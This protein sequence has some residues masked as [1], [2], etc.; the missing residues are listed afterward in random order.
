M[1][2]FCLYKSAV[3][4]LKLSVQKKYHFHFNAQL[5]VIF[6]AVSYENRGF[7]ILIT[8]KRQFALQEKTPFVKV[9]RNYTYND[10]EFK[11]DQFHR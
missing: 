6:L 5:V 1:L 8:K 10:N 2:T 3:A 9:I 7:I 11:V 4:S